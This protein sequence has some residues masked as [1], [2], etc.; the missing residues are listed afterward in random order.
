LALSCSQGAVDPGPAV[1]LGNGGGFD[2]D[3]VELVEQRAN[4]VDAAPEDVGR[5]VS[6]AL[7]YEANT[8]WV[9]AEAAWDAALRFDPDEPTWL[10][11]KGVALAQ[12]G[13]IQEALG[14][15]ERAIALDPAL[16]A[17]RFR[18]GLLQLELGEDELALASF[19]E[20]V[21]RQASGPA[22][23]VGVAEA[24][25]NLEREQEAAVACSK[26]IELDPS[27]K[28]AHYVLGMAYRGL[29]RLEDAE[30]ELALGADSEPRFVGDSLSAQ[31]NSYRRGYGARIQDA[32]DLVNAGKPAQAVPLLEQVVEG[33]P[34]DR[35][36]LVNL[37]V[38]YINV[39]RNEDSIEVL[40]RAHELDE[41]DFAVLINLA[42]AEMGLQRMADALKHSEQAVRAA[43][44][45][46]AT[47][48]MRSHAY[49]AHGRVGEAFTDLK[50]AASL[51]TGDPRYPIEAGDCAV[52]MGRNDEAIAFY[53]EGLKLQPNYLP[54]LVSMGVVAD[55]LGRR[56]VAEDAYRRAKAL[57]PNHE[58]VVQLGQRLGLQ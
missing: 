2:A 14:C 37:G 23:H 3:V 58:R 25:V 45:V 46:S 48:Y 13:Q 49:L 42:T 29:G 8:L 40:K 55:K 32:L 5:R 21:K 11:H 43:P 52:R 6:L 1:R 24:L 19:R 9:E 12:R 10:T 33:H 50:K 17:A 18:L 28:R 44:N 15:F 35:V 39:G 26:A 31:L 34:D 7:A 27:F 20:V 30:R 36:A 38:A 41:S 57:Q 56:S 53:A 54:A 51:D 16:D 47:Y 22:A 4:A